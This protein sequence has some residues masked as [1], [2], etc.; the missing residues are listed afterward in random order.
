MDISSNDSATIS[1]SK[2]TLFASQT[3]NA[4]SL[5]LAPDMRIYIARNESKN[6]L[7]VINFPD[8]VGLG[9]GFVDTGISLGASHSGWG[10][11]NLM[12]YG[13]YCDLEPNSTS[14]IAVD[15]KIN[16]SPNPFSEYALL[17]F[18]YLPSKKYRLKIFSILGIEM[19]YP[20][21]IKNNK[22]RI[23]RRNLSNGVYF[24]QL[25]CD[26]STLQTGK[27]CID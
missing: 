14:N 6:Y 17:E 16:M 4:Y 25:N 24:Y 20:I 21:E 3:S 1:N 26:G 11:N 12:E 13:Y 22:T 10:L 2:T 8:I 7:S 18:N 23:E 19:Q 15:N 5:K 9:C 27:F